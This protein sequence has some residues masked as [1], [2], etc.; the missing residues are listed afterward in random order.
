[1]RNT[2]KSIEGYKWVRIMLLQ[3]KRIASH[4]FL[5]ILPAS[6]TIVFSIHV[7]LLPQSHEYK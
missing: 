4:S 7:L 3:L 1:M 5:Y 2:W 6:V